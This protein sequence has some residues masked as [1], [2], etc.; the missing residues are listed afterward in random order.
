[1]GAFDAETYLRLLGERLLLSGEPQH[2]R[3]SPLVLPA[4]ALVVAGLLDPDC[5]AGVVDDY[6]S[7][8]A[9]RSG[10]RGF[11]AS[12]LPNARRPRGKLEPRTTML[13]NHEIVFGDGLLLLHDLSITPSAAKLRFRWRSDSA[14]A[15]RG[16][17]MFAHGGAGFPWGTA[18]PVIKD[19]QGRRAT[20]GAGGGSGNDS[21]WDGELTLQGALSPTTAW[22]EVEGTRVDLDRRIAP[23]RTWVEPILEQGAIERFLWRHLAVPEM[24][25][26]HQAQLAPAIDALRA[27]G[28]LTGDEAMIDELAAVSAQ[29]PGRHGRLRGQ[30]GQIGQLPQGT[31]RP[32]PEAWRALLSR[33]GRSDGPSWTRVLGAVSDPFDDIQ[34]AFH[35]V[36]SG[37]A[38]FEADF[39]A[40]PNVL[41]PSALGQLPV[42]WWARDDRGNRYLGQPNGWGGNEDGAS[43]TMQYWPA[44]DPEA[45]ELQ[46]VVS[47]DRH[48]AVIAV[49]LVPVP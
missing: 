33:V 5:A 31:G 1:M 6:T 47:A 21:Q 36:S 41:H 43:G 24:P 28:V 19:D 26:G 14:R 3:Q 8:L 39:E 2:H 27:A 45:T 30:L 34:V 42:V 15:S 37:E 13:L 16:A 10:Q 23:S 18:A 9:L 12:G 38:G 4:S 46:L 48:Q 32:V 22:L 25:F 17:R 20:V 7:A 35:S 49:P 44:L 11:V 40:S 29:L